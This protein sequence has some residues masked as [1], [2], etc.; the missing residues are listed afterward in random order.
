MGALLVASAFGTAAYAAEPGPYIPNLLIT[1]QVSEADVIG[2]AMTKGSS[3]GILTGEIAK[4]MQLKLQVTTPIRMRVV[5][6][7]VDKKGCQIMYTS[8]AVTGINAAKAGVADGSYVFT[9]KLT[10]CKE[11]DGPIVDV[12]HCDFAGSNCMPIDTRI[13]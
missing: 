11:N 2:E 12:I 7:V 5:K 1:R 13:N 3:E 6:G 10:L 9:N 4:Q 8:M